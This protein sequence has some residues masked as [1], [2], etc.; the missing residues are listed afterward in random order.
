MSVIP[1]AKIFG[2]NSEVADFREARV[3][4]WPA[5][6]QDQHIIGTHIEIRVIN[7]LLEV[8]DVLR[9]NRAAAVLQQ[10]V[11]ADGF[12]IA[13]VGARLPRSTTIPPGP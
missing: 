10:F 11:A 3:A 5:V 6:F 9:D 8:I 13:P 7:L 2:G 4:L 12:R 1:W